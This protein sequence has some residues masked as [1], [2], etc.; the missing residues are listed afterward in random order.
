ME[1]E[2]LAVGVGPGADPDYRNLDTFDQ[3]LRDGS[4]D[5]LE[6]DRE[7]AGI[8]E[9]ERVTGHL[10]GTLGRTALRA[11]TAERGGGLRRQANVA[12]DR[13]AGV[14]DR[15]G[16]LDARPAAFELDRVAAG[17]LDEALRC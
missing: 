14:N 10:E 16:A 4:W 15:P 3:L 13:D 2:Y 11:V 7:T 5:R 1:D 17:L 6:N 8:L 12:H 9:R